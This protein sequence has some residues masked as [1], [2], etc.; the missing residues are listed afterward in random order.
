MLTVAELIG[1]VESEGEARA[2]GSD[3]ILLR[4][5]LIP[6]IFSISSIKEGSGIFLPSTATSKPPCSSNESLLAKMVVFWRDI[7]GF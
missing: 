6:L 1:L 4:E 5:L 2:Y 7:G 3:A